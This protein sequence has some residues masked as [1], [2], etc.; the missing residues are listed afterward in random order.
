MASPIIGGR[1]GGFTQ[2]QSTGQ[3]QP[4]GDYSPET[5]AELARSE[6]RRQIA[7][8]LA[9]QGLAGGPASTQAGRFVVPRGWAQNVGDLAKVV[10][11][12]Y[13]NYAAD[14]SGK[15]AIEGENKNYEKVLS[16]YQQRIAPTPATAPQQ[17]IGTSE[18]ENTMTAG[19]PA[20]PRTAAE[21]QAAISELL[22][23]SRIPRVQQYGF[24]QQGVLDTTTAREDTQKEAALARKEAADL[25]RELTTAT[26]EEKEREAK[27]RLALQGQ[28]AELTAATAKRGQDLP[29]QFTTVIGKDGRAVVIDGRT[30]EVMGIAPSD[31]KLQG[32]FNQD[33]STL[34]S[35]VSDL[36]RLATKANEILE[37]PGLKG[38]TGMRGAI[39]N[40]PG[41]DAADAEAKLNTLK[42]QIAFSVLQTMRNNSKTGGA[43]GNVSDAEGKRLEGNLQELD[44]AQ[45][46]DQ[47]KQAMVGI[48]QY[49]EEAKGRMREAYNMKHG[50]KVEQRGGAPQTVPVFTDAP[51][52]KAVGD[53]LKKKGQPVATWDGHAWQP[54]TK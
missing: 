17:V 9:Q 36:D 7:N 21:R 35:T 48:K 34:N 12:A 18:D 2:F 19:T 3:N 38:I 44:K 49:V 29:M 47:F 10:A 13:G 53:T 54:I 23:S 33:T 27:D 25:K 16:A 52:G 45:S 46:L 41:T 1:A 30:K 28:M 22:A 37:H 14:Q 15:E 31:P 5:Q 24:Q 20:M 11:G 4:L 42:S 43:L 40:F 50:E 6:R 26:L 39:P 51:A 8:L 32:V